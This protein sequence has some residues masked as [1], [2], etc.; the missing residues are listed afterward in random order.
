MPN[1]HFIYRNHSGEKVFRLAVFNQAVFNQAVF[2][3]LLIRMYFLSVPT[4]ADL[5][6]GGN[7]GHANICEAQSTYICRGDQV[8][9]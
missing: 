4:S 8:I 2:N 9:C 5:E 7:P 1:P 3:E 6:P